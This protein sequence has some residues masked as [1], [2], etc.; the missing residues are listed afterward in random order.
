MLHPEHLELKSL[1]AQSQLLCCCRTQEGQT[2]L[3][4]LADVDIV[5]V[6]A[7]HLPQTLCSQQPML[8][9]YT[10]NQGDINEGT[11]STAFGVVFGVPQ[12]FQ[13]AVSTFDVQ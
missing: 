8:V 10:R 2:Q 12:V 6:S 1:L 13:S 9:A 3:K 5:F 7:R 4:K 11:L